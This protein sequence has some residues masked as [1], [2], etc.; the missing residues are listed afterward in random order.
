[1]PE[2]NEAQLRAIES[3]GSDLLVSAGAGSGKTAVLVERLLRRVTQEGIDVDRFLVVTFTRAA[4]SEMLAKFSRRLSD[5]VALHPDDRRLRRQ[6]RLLPRAQVTTVHGFCSAVLREHFQP[7]GLPPD[8]RIADETEAASLRA[9]TLDELIE[10]RYE[11]QDEEFLALSDAL[12][13][14]RDDTRLLRVVQDVHAR[15]T[16]HPDPAAWARDVR[17]SAEEACL[18]DP[19]DTP[20]GAYLAGEARALLRYHITRYEALET[21]I[22]SEPSLVAYAAC[23]DTELA[24]LRELLTVFETG[25][26]D[27]ARTALGSVSFARLPAARSAA[28]ED[29]ELVKSVR[30]DWKK[31][32]E[33]LLGR[34]SRSAAD[35]MADARTAL[36][37]THALMRLVLDFDAAFTD[38]KRRRGVVDFADLEHLT[39]GLLRLP[40][41][42]PTPLARELSAHFTEILVD[43]YQDTNAVQDSIF[44][45]LS[46][47]NLFMVGDV[48]QSIYRFRLADPSIFL[49][50]YNTY[51]DEPAEEGSPRRVIL[52]ANYR[53]RRQVLDAVNSAM[54]RLF[55]PSLGELSYTQ[56]EF[57]RPG[58]VFPDVPDADYTTELQLIPHGDTEEAEYAAGRIAQMVREGFPVTDG[59]GIRPA[60]WGDFAILMRSYSKSAPVFARVLEAHG[61]PC[62]LAGN[63]RSLLEAPEIEMLTAILSC[64]DNPR[65]D[66][67]LA[68][69]ARA[70]FFAFTADDLAAVRSA[71]P[72]GPFWKAVFR[73]AES[74][75]AGRTPAEDLPDVQ[76]QPEPELFRAAADRSA[77]L[78]DTLSELRRAA[79]TMPLGRFL[80]HM[81]DRL[82]LFTA[83][84]AMENAQTRRENLLA[85]FSLAYRFEGSGYRG[86]YRFLRRIRVLRER[87]ESP[88]ALAP[89]GDTDAVRIMSIHRSKGLQFPIVL[90]AGCGG[91]FNTESGRAPVLL[92]PR[93]GLGMRCRRM[94][95][96][97]EYPTV[98]QNAVR[99]CLEREMLSEELRVL[100]VGMT[101]AEEKLILTASVRDPAQFLSDIPVGDACA[102]MAL[103][104]ES[105]FAGWLARALLPQMQADGCVPELGWRIGTGQLPPAQ[106]QECPVWEEPPVLPSLSPEALSWVYPY[107]DAP[108]TPSKL[109]ATALARLR[110]DA[111]AQ[112]LP[113]LRDGSRQTGARQTVRPRFIGQRGLT[114]SERGTALHLAMQFI[115]Y[116]RAL[117]IFD[118]RRELE[119]LRDEA[120]ITPAEA[121]AVDPQRIVRFFHSEL[122]QRLR[123]SPE[124][125]REF[126]FSVP[127]SAALHT[128]GTLSPPAPGEDSI[129][130]QGVVDCCFTEN[131][132]WVIVDFKTDAAASAAQMRARYAPQLSA[133]AHAVARVTGRRVRE[134]ALYLFSTGEAV[135]VEFPRES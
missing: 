122:G 82:E 48:K 18:K 32:H 99:A 127:V 21:L 117:T 71:T 12:S 96:R 33:T 20:A 56:R 55:S 46:R 65:Q 25:G 134:C 52:S 44:T 110:E 104:R 68:A 58:R 50:R 11:A 77:F 84:A 123:R 39:L 30:G 35:A 23:I 53:S 107:A 103:A 86:L 8:F 13:A 40:D 88:A 17:L 63:P 85:F 47:N 128:H 41:G 131:G 5:A 105:S 130:L 28:A 75:R 51:P 27:D 80:W 43:E 54:E 67:A 114:S 91:R 38:A 116:E 42:S 7:A 26:W 121:E 36:P 93:L 100:Y 126:R 133:Y 119:R 6:L 97:I 106:P 108:D 49:N 72:E 29:R 101:R 61:V 19:A 34:F 15:M 3:R 69:A 109:T 98:A 1:M 95:E 14:A 111:D 31:A 70:P 66:I 2:W 115:R 129:L 9:Q 74:S 4:A 16:A 90:L 125:R 132:E 64:V 120:F 57:L 79:E 59:D 78:L 45:A 76:A 135:R 24:A 89:S 112:E 62:T 10:A 73:A 83:L 94:S 113:C 92:H 81:A 22:A 102:P 124:L 37:L 87:G 118:C 60:R